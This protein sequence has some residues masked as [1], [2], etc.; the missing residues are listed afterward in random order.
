MMSWLPIVARDLLHTAAR[1]ALSAMRRPPRSA[2][3]EFALA[4]GPRKLSP[5]V[6]I[7]DGIGRHAS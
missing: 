3:R 7:V 4:R 1:A 2:R 6:K 5:R